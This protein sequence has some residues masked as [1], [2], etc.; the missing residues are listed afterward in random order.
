MKLHESAE[1]SRTVW[2]QLSISD[3]CALGEKVVTVHPGMVATSMNEANGKNKR[4]NPAPP[5]PHA[6]KP[7]T[8]KDVC[9]HTHTLQ[10]AACA[11]C[12]MAGLIM[13]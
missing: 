8:H 10:C 9:A 11:K 3:C 2:Q 7:H 13:I 1:Q 6:H 4:V 5:P 12:C